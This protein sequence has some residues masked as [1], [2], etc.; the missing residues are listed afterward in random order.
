MTLEK[1]C[2]GNNNQKH[3][4]NKRGKENN[5]SFGDTETAQRSENG[6]QKNDTQSLQAFQITTEVK[7][8]DLIWWNKVLEILKSHLKCFS[9][10]EHIGVRRKEDS[11]N[12]ATSYEILCEKENLRVEVKISHLKN[13]VS[14]MVIIWK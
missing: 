9:L 6:R 14:N 13:P 1:W 4:Q 5:H 3:S 11:V 7:I 12:H 2:K 10:E 8:R